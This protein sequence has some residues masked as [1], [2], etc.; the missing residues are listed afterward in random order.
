MHFFMAFKH[1][2]MSQVFLG[3]PKV[4]E[5]TILSLFLQLHLSENLRKNEQVRFA[6]FYDVTS[7]HVPYTGAVK[8]P[9]GVVP[10]HKI[11]AETTSLLAGAKH[12]TCSDQSEQTG[13]LEA[14]LKETG[15]K[16]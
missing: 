7:E 5:K 1:Q 4:W 16:T 10:A 15:A 2:Y 6:D 8:Q 13:F 12:A 9:P 3:T 14:G 11:P